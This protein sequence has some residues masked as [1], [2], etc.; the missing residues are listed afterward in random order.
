MIGMY[1]SGVA[2]AIARGAADAAQ[3]GAGSSLAL[4]Q[5]KDIATT[6]IDIAQE[7]SATPIQRAAVLRAQLQAAVLEQRPLSTILELQAKVA[8]ADRQVQVYLAGEQSSR[9]WANL[10]KIALAMGIGVGGALMLLLATRAF[11]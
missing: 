1:G 9:E 6:A 11:R 8:A 7:V 5:V 3:E 2:P 10:G 4:S